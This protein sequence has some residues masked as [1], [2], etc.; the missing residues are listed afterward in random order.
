MAWLTAAVV[1]CCSACGVLGAEGTPGGTT[2]STLGPILTTTSPD[3]TTTTTEPAVLYV[4]QAGDTIGQVATEHGLTADRLTSFNGITIDTPLR[5]GQE[6][7]VPLSQTPPTATVATDAAP[8]HRDDSGSR[9]TDDRRVTGAGDNG[10]R[11]DDDH[12]GRAGVRRA[13]RR[14]P[15]GDRVRPR[16]PARSAP[17]C[18]RAPGRLG[19]P[20]GPAA[21]RAGPGPVRS[22][23]RRRWPVSAADVALPLPRTLSPSKL[24]LFKESALAFRYSAID[25]VPEPAS[26]AAVRGTLVH[27]RSSC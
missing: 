25:R 5:I 1:A 9:V 14:Q 16:D 17:R 7:L 20:P 6:I 11:P 21:R 15:A 22:G 8:T 24:T 23:G 3:L 2:T 18:Q 4:I 13:A 26:V 10:P 12:G 27:P 19:H